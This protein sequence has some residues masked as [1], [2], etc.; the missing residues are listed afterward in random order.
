[1]QAGG[2]LPRQATMSLNVLI[3]GVRDSAQNRTDQLEGTVNSINSQT[4][5]RSKD[6]I[7]ILPDMEAYY[8]GTVIKTMWS[9]WKGR[10]IYQC[11]KEYRTKK[12]THT[13]TV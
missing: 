11:W 7:V 10:H 2:Q 12:Y 3:E 8:I 9:R 6:R 5:S 13:F 4:L 1:M